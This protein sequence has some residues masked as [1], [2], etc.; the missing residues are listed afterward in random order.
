M[1]VTSVLLMALLALA[2]GAWLTRPLWSKAT[3]ATVRR[4]RA[5]VVA[6]ETR[7]AEI[8]ADLA[9]GTLDAESAQ[10]LRDEAAARLLHD[11]G[12]T[13]E[14]GEAPRRPLAALLAVLVLLV[15]AGLAYAVAGN[16]QTRALIDLAQRDP[17]AAERQMIDGMIARL[18]TRL[19]AQPDDAQGWAM[20]GRSYVVTQRY[21]EA[22][23]AYARANAL[24]VEQPQ[25][26]WLV[27]AGAAQGLASPERD[28]RPSR[29]LFEQ[30]LQLDP[31]HAEALWYAG[32][33]A[34]QA[35]DAATAYRH[36]LALRDQELPE[37]VSAVLEQ[38]L[39]QLAQKAGQTL[40]PKKAGPPA[41]AGL[42]L[43]VNVR[44]AD[45]LRAQ[46]KPGMTLLVFA[47]AEDGPPM[48]LA[49]QRIASP[50][51][52]LTVTLDDSMAMLPAMKLSSFGRW[53]VT[54]RL[55][56][57]AGAEAL[58]GDLEGRHPAS[59]AE[60]GTPVDL[61]IDRQLP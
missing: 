24:S 8:D 26:D 34:L 41:A 47:K 36:W 18:E 9:A 38:Q 44:L 7:V 61:L 43:T 57:G 52:P 27:A 40:P 50:T 35:G 4:R 60:A 33:A 29:A 45:A 3:A 17:Q 59:R 32:L 56:S 23:K 15:G 37:D 16:W 42:R 2:A 22:A 21:A 28:L 58:S 55:T 48:P 53:V 20:L 19:K 30:A 25:A 10:P 6:Y 13:A 14:A 1:N 11:A 5:N 54:A 49:V 51:L 12:E 31:G 46:L 39:P